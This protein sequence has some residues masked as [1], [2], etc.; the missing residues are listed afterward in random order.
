MARKSEFSAN[1]VVQAGFRLVDRLGIEQLTAR[2]LA[3]E[4]GSSTAPVYSNF[5]NMEQLEAAVISEAIRRLLKYTEVETS[6]EP[7]ASIGLGV[8][9][10]AWKHPR[11]YEALFLVARP[12]SDPG[13]QIMEEFLEAMDSMARF[14]GLSIAERTIV[15]KKMAIFT[16]GVATEICLRGGDEHSMEEWKIL[17][18]EIGCTIVEDAFKR[19]PRSAQ[20]I[21]LLGSLC[22]CCGQNKPEKGES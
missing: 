13:L 10:F 14:D 12:Q 19:A 6:D 15:L 22:E 7:F 16:H 2:Q 9:N 1:D 17:L 5:S 4:L 3:E 8:L 18:D 20:E 21:K 11:W